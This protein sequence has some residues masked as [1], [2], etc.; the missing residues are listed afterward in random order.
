MKWQLTLKL[1]QTDETAT[2]CRSFDDDDP[3]IWQVW[4]ERQ[5]KLISDGPTRLN[6]GMQ[7]QQRLEDL[8][9]SARG[10]CEISYEDESN[11]SVHLHIQEVIQEIHPNEDRL[12]AHHLLAT[13]NEVIPVTAREELPFTTPLQIGLEESQPTE[14][15]WSPSALG[16]ARLALCDADEILC[17]IGVTTLS[18]HLNYLAEFLYECRTNML[19]TGAHEMSVFPSTEDD[20][21]FH[22]PLTC[23][24]GLNVSLLR[25]HLTAVTGEQLRSAMMP[26]AQSIYT[27]LD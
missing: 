1:S 9:Y 16:V 25:G 11:L 5:L 24:S 15:H 26:V 19:K 18:G 13:F 12:L 21:P 10:T 20:D 6:A 27:E 7:L 3:N 2:L 14:H 4:I 8:R 17:A 22:D 23:T